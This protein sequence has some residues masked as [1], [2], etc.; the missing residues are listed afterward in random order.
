MRIKI[1]RQFHIKCCTDAFP[2]LFAEGKFER[3]N[4]GRQQFRLSGVKIDA[5]LDNRR[6]LFNQFE[7]SNSLTVESYISPRIDDKKVLVRWTACN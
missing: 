3:G 5:A 1:F 6:S 7:M 4:P 2:N